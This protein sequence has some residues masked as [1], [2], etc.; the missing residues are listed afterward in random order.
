M[1]IIMTVYTDLHML[2]LDQA[3][4]SQAKTPKA[5]QCCSKGE[6][7]LTASSLAASLRS[8]GESAF[9]RQDEEV[10]IHFQNDM[11]CQ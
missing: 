1:D 8:V 7:L 9:S 10:N 2:N 6:I 3:A 4:Y 5:A 11:Q